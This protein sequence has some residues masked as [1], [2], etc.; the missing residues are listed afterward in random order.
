MSRRDA[1][2]NR[3]GSGPPPS[4]PDI[5]RVLRRARTRQGLR[6]ED[7][8]VRTGLPVDQ[9]EA[10]EAGAVAAI[11]D[12]VVILKT[13]RRYADFLGLPGERLVVT[14]VEL[15]PAPGSAPGKVTATN[16]TVT[17][18]GTEGLG[19]GSRRRPG[20]P[21]TAV[22]GPVPGPSATGVLAPAGHLAG[23][24]DTGVYQ[25]LDPTAAHPAFRPPGPGPVDPLVSPALSAPDRARSGNRQGGPR[26][27]RLLVI[28]V[29]VAIVV[30]VTGLIL[31]RA[32][33]H[34]FDHLGLGH[35]TSAT[36]S[37]TRATSSTSRGHPVPA[38]SVTFT[39]TSA[40]SGTADVK[41]SN[42]SL[43]IA[44]TSGQCWVDVTSAGQSS[45]LYAQLINSGNQQDFPIGQTLTV[46]LGSAA[47]HVFVVR[48][49]KVIGSYIPQMA[50][51]TLTVSGPS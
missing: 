33:P 2:V 48:H 20:D 45:P 21:P 8:A 24:I 43:R 30:G 9:L 32:E 44:V 3:M 34:W 25:E 1:D 18:P 15:W 26:A 37:T 5:G 27:L 7:V 23:G 47:G 51:F 22:V 19:T 29:A 31:Y 39:T 17:G 42:A 28:L 50:P 14:M 35:D 12:R 36:T 10:L 49:G 40:Y 13:L 16:P 11:P 41:V 38:D 4:F 46:Q 6:F